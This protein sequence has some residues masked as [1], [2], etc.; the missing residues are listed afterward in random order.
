M[1]LWGL[2]IRQKE[3]PTPLKVST[4]IAQPVTGFFPRHQCIPDVGGNKR[5]DKWAPAEQRAHFAAKTPKTCFMLRQWRETRKDGNTWRH[6]G[7]KAGP[8]LNFPPYA[9]NW[10]AITYATECMKAP[11]DLDTTCRPVGDVWVSPPEGA[12]PADNDNGRNGRNYRQIL[13]SRSSF[14]KQT[15]A[16][17]SIK[18]ATEWRVCLF[19]PRSSAFFHL[20]FYI[21][22]IYSPLWHRCSAQSHAGRY[23][24]PLAPTLQRHFP[25]QSQR[26]QGKRRTGC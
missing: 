4:W 21:S 25:P 9:L 19:F 20:L 24:A 16:K 12:E 15:S 10:T 13:W 11:C 17:R 5:S 2:W 22:Y 1:V 18:A 7:W 26:I 3:S 23:T 14:Y 8:W 6:E